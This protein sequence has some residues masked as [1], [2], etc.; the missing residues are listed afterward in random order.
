MN[1]TA[2]LERE[3]LLIARTLDAFERFARRV[4]SDFE[5]DV[6][7]LLR[8]STFCRDFADACHHEK[9]EAIVIPVLQRTALAPQQSTIEAILR[10]H[11]TER[12]ML[13]AIR[14]TGLAPN[15]F[16]GENRF[17]IAERIHAFVGFMR[18]HIELE[19]TTLFPWVR[20]E[21]SPAVAAEIQSRC[22]EFDR[23]WSETE[24]REFLL[25]VAEGL[26]ARYAPP[27]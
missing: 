18:R 8:F 26:C 5:P 2:C 16:V 4:A 25:E 13:R 23:T 12:L 10:E 7:D 24:D 11:A 27:T 6:L 20:A 15:P 21:V 9:E 17:R 3:H 22:E 1:P 14:R 19:E